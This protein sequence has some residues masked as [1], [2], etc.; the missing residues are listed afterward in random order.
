LRCPPRLERALDVTP[1]VRETRR[2]KI[3]N[4]IATN[5]DAVGFADLG[6]TPLTVAAL[7]HSSIFEPVAVQAMAIP[8]LLEGR[9]VVMQASTG[10]GKTLAFLVPLAERLGRPAAGPRGLVV[11]PT[12][13]L[14]IQVHGVL[15]ALTPHTKTALLYGG[16]G[17]ASQTT[18]LRGGVDVVVGTPGRLLDM[19]GRKQLSLSRVEYLVLDEADVMFDAGFAPDVERILGL[20]YHPQTVLASATMPDW[21][22]RMVERH[23]K[24]P[25]VVRIQPP[26]EPT[27]E[28][29]LLQVEAEQKLRTLSGVLKRHGSSIVFGRTKHGVRKLNRELQRLGHNSVELQGDMAQSARERVMA[30]FRQARSDVLVAT[31]VAARGLDLTGVELVVNYELPETPDWLTHRVGRTARNGA[32]GRALTFV[33]PQDR[34]A[35]NR[36]R[37][38]GAPS[39]PVVDRD[40]LLAGEWIYVPSG[41]LRG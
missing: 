20:T 29:G 22:A 35:W 18:A 23:L 7:A 6:V 10:S 21:V 17:Y 1:A 37:R 39:L 31:N 14:A 8:L 38:L 19:V 13:E 36:L 26:A 28:H 33:T 41:K 40:R 3:Q 11:V 32:G 15:A 30:G 5:S 24:D 4:A 12:R 16:I 2:H 9:D 25:A 27:L 34:I